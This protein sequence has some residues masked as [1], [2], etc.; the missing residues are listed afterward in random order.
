ML[1]HNFVAFREQSFIAF[2]GES[3]DYWLSCSTSASLGLSTGLLF[4]LNILAE[5]SS[6][7]S[8]TSH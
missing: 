5:T 2:V 6:T 7:S 8:M 3:V 4:A 1:K